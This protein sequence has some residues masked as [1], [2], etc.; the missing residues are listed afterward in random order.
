M[1]GGEGKIEMEI[2]EKVTK[3]RKR[4]KEIETGERGK[5]SR[6]RMG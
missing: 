5:R 4:Q 3:G 6:K 2:R 1:G